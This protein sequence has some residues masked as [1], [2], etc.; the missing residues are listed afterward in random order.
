MELLSICV[1]SEEQSISSHK[2]DSLRGELYSLY[3]NVVLI[4]DFDFKFLV[5][6]T[7]YYITD[8][9]LDFLTEHV[10]LILGY[11][12]LDVVPH[13]LLEQAFVLFRR[14][15]RDLLVETIDGP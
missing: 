10:F 5:I 9:N 13:Q 14:N 1:Q 7:H 15:G 2:T 6:L 3:L 11:D 4:Q 12:D 8:H